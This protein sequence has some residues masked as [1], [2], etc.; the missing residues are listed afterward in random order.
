MD[1]AAG[2]GATEAEQP[3][4]DRESGKLIASARERHSGR[5]AGARNLSQPRF[6]PGSSGLRAFCGKPPVRSRVVP[7]RP[8]AIDR[9]AQALP[10]I[11]GVLT[12]ATQIATV[13]V[14]KPHAEALAGLVNH[15]NGLRQMRR[16]RPLLQQLDA[17]KLAAAPQI[18]RPRSV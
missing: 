5:A 3:A 15:I 17:G 10:Q 16:R 1:H 13:T 2:A 7:F 11:A 6:S 12:P 9:I 4:G 8:A 14:G 18:R